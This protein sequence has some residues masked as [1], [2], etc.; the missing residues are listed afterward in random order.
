MKHS[1]NETWRALA[2]AGNVPE[3]RKIKTAVI[4]RAESMLESA[5][6]QGR[7]LDSSETREFNSLKEQAVE[8]GSLVEHSSERR[9]K[10]ERET[11]RYKQDNDLSFEW[12]SFL[13][14]DSV[15][16]EAD[17]SNIL[18]NRIAGKTPGRE[19]R[20]IV[21]TT[22]LGSVP[23]RVIDEIVLR[24]VTESAILQ[25]QPRLFNTASGETIKVPTFTAYGTASFLSEGSAYSESDPTASSVE[26]KAFKVG[27]LLQVSQELIDD[28]EFDIE[29]YLAQEL[30]VSV[31]V[32]I[33]NAIDGTNI[34]GSTAV[35]GAFSTATSVGATGTAA[36]GAPT[37]DDLITLFY[38]VNP[39][40]QVNGSWIMNPA[41]LKQVVGLNDTQGRSLLLP[42]LSQ[43]TPTTLLGRPVYLSDSVQSFGTG[44]KSSVIFG[45]IS[46]FYYVRFAG[47]L[48]LVAS[49]EFALN[50][51]LVTYRIDSRV[52]GRVVDTNAAKR[53]VGIA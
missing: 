35:Q 47:G 24:L 34:G 2:L 37:V 33:A 7:D 22:G 27:R 46:K 49:P 1:S 8:L 32:A 29:S 41:T 4:A 28:T 38:S 14:G 5:Q 50:T 23:T 53:F 45:D 42:S 31:G 43:D 13:K 11:A 12:R 30:G 44:S 19:R 6:L 25:A 10:T 3:L 17:Y 26:L 40:Y 51:G 16:V 39:R 20:D 48:K 9:A 15:K 36:N 52:D 21:T 18:A